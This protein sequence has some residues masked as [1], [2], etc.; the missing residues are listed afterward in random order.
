MTIRVIQYISFKRA[1]GLPSARFVT[2]KGNKGG[3]FGAEMVKAGLS[4]LVITGKSK[5]PV[6]LFIRDRRIDFCD[7]RKLKGLN[8]IETQERGH[9]S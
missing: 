8:T 6:Y 3:E 7:A 4:H 1:G 2:G 5:R 9:P